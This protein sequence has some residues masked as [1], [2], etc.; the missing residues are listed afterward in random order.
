[1]PIIFSLPTANNI[2]MKNYL[3][4]SLKYLTAVSAFF[5][6][7]LGLLTARA[8]GYSHPLLR[9]LYFTAQSNVWI[10]VIML[11]LAINLSV[12]KQTSG[13]GM[14]SLYFL[15]YVFTVSITLTALVFCL[16][17]AP[18]SDASYR[19][20]TL[21]NLFTHVIT[22][23]LSL[24][25]FF[26]DRPRFIL[27]KNGAWACLLPPCLYLLYTTVLCLFRID[28]GRGVP[29]PYFFMNVFSPVGIFGVSS[30]PPFIL[31]SAYW[32]LLL[33]MVVYLIGRLYRRFSARF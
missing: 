11:V 29:Y 32:Y 7:I 2:R 26:L 17:L 6:V 12:S 16:L 3:R 18:F 15:R 28:F 13:A 5:G 31:G 10:G 25:D 8:D 4:I 23:A 9:L 20:W 14:R 30:Q 22:P 19:P 24:L 1:M 21:T 33:A 27:P